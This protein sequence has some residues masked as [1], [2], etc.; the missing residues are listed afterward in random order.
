MYT[1]ALLLIN[2]VGNMAQDRKYKKYEWMLNPGYQALFWLFTFL[3]AAYASLYAT[4]IKSFILPFQEN[5]G[6][7]NFHT[8]GFITGA[9]IAAGFFSVS[10][11]VKARREDFV[12]HAMQTSPPSNFWER[13]YEAFLTANK[14][15]TSTE[16]AA[17]YGNKKMCNDNVRIVLDLLIN[18]VK[19][20]DSA[21]IEKKVVY[22]ANLMRVVNFNNDPNYEVS[23]DDRFFI[24][25]AKEHYSG[26]VVLEDYNYTTTTETD[27]STPDR[28]RKPITFPYC[29]PE[30]SDNQKFHTNL[31]GAP[32]CIATGCYDY[33]KDVNSIVSHYKTNAD[34]LSNRVKS[35]LEKYYS[36]KNNP[37]HSIL[38]IP[39][40]G[41]VG[42]SDNKE[43]KWVLNIYR[44]QSG[45]LYDGAKC[46]DFNFVSGSFT[47]ILEEMM[48]AIE[49]YEKNPESVE[50]ELDPE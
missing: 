23:S 34:P 4:E 16:L 32:Y 14:L 28:D 7:P 21:N 27:E 3:L 1:I 41:S 15:K 2:V 48:Q 42:E 40:F 45:M 35:N 49:Y 36:D 37:A 5:S 25:P 13:H 19:E 38:S 12:F 10:T 26:V 11:W 8:I 18:L 31:R 30:E 39:L 22:R 47:T 29:L 43:V 46:K 17:S 33:V 6:P 44:N 20:W 9:L 24:T 50:I